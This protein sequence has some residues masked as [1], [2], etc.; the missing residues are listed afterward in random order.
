MIRVIERLTLVMLAVGQMACAGESAKKVF[1]HYMVCIPTYGGDSKIADYQ[2]EIR[3]AQAAG[4]DGFALNCGGWTLR[5]PHYKQRSLL[6]YQAAKELG[7]DFKLFFSADYAT[8]LTSDETRDMVETFRSHP[9][10]F[11]YDNKPV[12]STFAGGRE[13]TDF[14][15]KEFTGDRAIV[16]V[17]FY[18]PNPAAEMPNQAQVDQVFSDHQPLDGFF[19]FGAAGTSAQITESNRLLAQ[20]WLG[21]GKLFMASVT[22]YY[23]GL[24]GNYRI[25]DSRGF[26][27]FAQQWEGA[28]R[29]KATWVEIVT[30][31]D[32]GE[33]SYVAPFG[34]PFQTRHWNNNWGPMLSHAAFLDASRYFI[35]WFKRGTPPKIVEDA[36]Y[37]FYRTHPKAVAGLVKPGD[38]EKKTA[39]PG[40]SDKLTDEVFATLFLTAP[41]RL[42]IHSG[43]TQKSFDRAAGVCHV[44]M[45]FAPGQQRFVLTRSNETVID[46]TGEQEI[47]AADAWGNFNV[48][49]GEAKPLTVRVQNT[50]GGP[51]I[52]VNGTPVPPRFF[53]G[54]ENSG[55][56]AVGEEWG[57]RSFEFTADADVAGNGTLHFRFANIPGE[58]WLSDLRLADAGTGAD[59]L[60]P[61]SFATQAAFG[62]TWSVWP[63]GAASTVGQADNAVYVTFNAPKDGGGWPDFHLHSR[64]NLSFVKGQ[65]YRCTFRVKAKPGQSL[66]PSVYRVDGGVYSCI[67]GPQGSFLSQVALARDAGV[68]LVSFAAPTCWAQPGQKQDWTPLDALCRRI[69]AANPDVLLV[70]RVDANAPNWWLASHPEARMVYDGQ[71]PWPVACV[72]DRT[73]RADMCAQL[74]KLAHHLCEAFPDRFAGLHPCGQ[75]TGEWFYYNSWERPLSGYDPATRTAFREWLKQR[76]D[77]AAATAEPP[78]SEERRGHPNGLLRDPSREGRLIEFARF[79]QQEMADFVAALAA[80]CLRGTDGKKLVLFFYGYGFE[81]PPLGNGAPTSGHYALGSLLKSKDIDILCSPISYTDREWLGTAPAMS[82]AESVKRAGILWLNEDDSRTYLD[83]RTVEHAQEGGLVDLKQTRQVM[84]RNT[85]QAALRGF[86]TWWMDLPGQGWFNDAAIW[87]EIVRLRPV[88]EAMA[89]RGRPFSPD[90]AAIIDEDS[91]CHLT[92]GSEQA[93]RPLIYE[94]RAALGRC[95]APYGQYLLSDVLEGKV[96]ARMQIFF[97]AWRLTAEQRKALKEKRLTAPLQ[98]V[99]DAGIWS[100]VK[101]WFGGGRDAEVT[102]VWCWAPGY[103]YPDRVDLAGIKEV[104]GFT[105]KPVTLPTAEVAPTELGRKNG[106]TQ[107]WGPKVPIQPLFSVEARPDEIL[108]AYSDGSAAVA[109][110]RSAAGLDVFVGVPQLTPELIQALAKASGV[111]LFTQP[112]P[113]L[114]ATDG[115]LSVQAHTNGPV[116][117]D[118]GRARPVSD[119][120]DGTRLGSGPRVELNMEQG[121]VRVLRY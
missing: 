27:G 11:R 2:R 40:G 79:Q 18:Y 110:R 75:N 48:F 84:L 22:P 107:A 10:Q 70:P 43:D 59:V 83:P 47:S 67:G 21:A 97:S 44:S 96:P 5:E 57:E 54:S 32:W 35:E 23:R 26:E 15:R 39:L 117:F 49:A 76:G 112:G 120:L 34:A 114:W 105:A 88:D 106:L 78:T 28:I 103:L 52:H 1:A 109:M 100:R 25:Y 108:A 104:T 31:N 63:P 68:N 6:I 93:A 116:L 50:A 118:T 12:L 41:A 92:G 115:Y 81:F 66:N 36:V 13:Q 29:D 7:T 94:G 16:Y 53:W 71:T 62:Q 3:A 89:R 77:P 87:R 46:K 14:I 99:D 24:G 86:G 90:I 42:T 45:P 33:A 91:M 58:V 55:R 85:A 4:I 111:H 82:A 95:G 119:A 61:G 73:Y 51:Q 101:G 65:T 98:T 56:I 102:R 17:P 19:N 37:Y 38:P 9:N 64:C 30:W 8:G 74:E 121:D 72:S 20:K 113:A 80:A 60:P 69:I